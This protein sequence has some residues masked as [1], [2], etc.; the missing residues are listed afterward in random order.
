MESV[1]VQNVFLIQNYEKGFSGN[2]RRNKN[3]EG[4]GRLT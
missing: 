4:P 1:S 3:F 2:M